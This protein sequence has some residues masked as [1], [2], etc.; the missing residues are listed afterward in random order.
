[1][2]DIGSAIGLNLF[3]EGIKKGLAGAWEYDMVIADRIGEEIF[4]ADRR[5]GDFQNRLR[6]AKASFCL[7]PHKVGLATEC[8]GQVT[9]NLEDSCRP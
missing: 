7:A 8:T 9:R 2:V 3:Q 4:R 6:A 5:I 1:M